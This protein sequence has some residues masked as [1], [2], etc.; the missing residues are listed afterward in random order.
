MCFLIKQ[1]EIK[2]FEIKNYSK[3]ILNN[4]KKK[5]FLIEKTFTNL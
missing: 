1:E 5:T 4:Y 3:N 2:H